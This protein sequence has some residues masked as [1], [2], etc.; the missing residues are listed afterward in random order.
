FPFVWLFGGL[1]CGWAWGALL[2]RLGAAMPTLAC[3]GWRLLSV[4]AALALV[5]WTGLQVVAA[6]DWGLWNHSGLEA[7]P[8]W[9]RLS[10]L[11]PALSGQLNSPRLTFE[12][13]PANNDI[14][15][16]R[17]LE[18]LPMFLGGRPVLEGLY[19]ESAPVGPAI[20]QLQSEVST[21]PS[22]PLARFP[23]GSLDLDSAAVHMNF[24][25]ANEVLIRHED[26]YKAFAAS[27]LFTEVASAA[28]FH[29]FRLKAF[30]SQWV[31]IVNP[32]QRTLR[33]LA[34]QGWLQASFAWFKSRERF[35]HE[36]PVFQAG[37]APQIVAP[38]A[39]AQVHDLKLER[40]HLSWRTDA[41][42]S[43]HLVRM[44]WHPRWKLATKGKLYLAGPG[45]MLVV[46]EEAQVQLDY[47]HTPIGLAG[48]VATAL[49]L[50]VLL[51]LTWRDGFGAFGRSRAHG[52][53]SSHR[54]CH[55]LPRIRSGAGTDPQSMQS[56]VMDT[57]SSP[58]MTA[59]S[60]PLTGRPWPGDWLAW[61]WP[62][63]LVCAGLWLHLN[64][65]ERLYT[66]AWALS[67][68]NH[69]LQAAAEFDRAYAARNSDAKKEEALFWAA[70]AYQQA[71]KT[72]LAIERYR[73]LN[74]R[75]H[76]YWLPESLYTQAQLQ[77]A[78]GASAPAQSARARLLQEFPNDRWAQRLKTGT[79]Q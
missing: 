28:P 39:L 15:S 18:A 33:W 48:M 17:A 53:E 38:A 61:L 29:V 8:Q 76:G 60:I 46:P 16:T 69:P 4:A 22:S 77:Q 42:G 35:S 21:H 56:G 36:L 6:P 54:G 11:F 30:D 27:P 44:A 79:A 70:K 68:A 59:S 75:F 57:G 52:M 74:D 78:A 47:G 13:D 5:G 41:V 62:L 73:E 26:T 7:K 24:L 71:G 37:A 51:A 63:L 66:A 34:P 19:M 14:G 65:P 31:D 49:A 50:L 72:E 1:A 64:N 58:G 23:S 20:Y 40:N 43:A 9:Q 12:H 3:W 55:C 2:L 25:W 45:F 10:Q 67:R 32:A